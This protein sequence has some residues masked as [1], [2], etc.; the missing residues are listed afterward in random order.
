MLDTIGTLVTAFRITL[1]LLILAGI[2]ALIVVFF[3]KRSIKESLK[4]QGFSKQQS[5]KSL[6]G[7]YLYF[8]ELRGRIALLDEQNKVF[9]FNSGDVEYAKVVV[10]DQEVTDLAFDQDIKKIDLHFKIPQIEHAYELEFLLCFGNESQI[11]RK[12]NQQKL[13]LACDWK[14]KISEHKKIMAG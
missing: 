7:R 8:D 5:F 11:N 9:I 6:N 13:E 14:R 2:I 10:N 12:V 4:K 1:N 3:K